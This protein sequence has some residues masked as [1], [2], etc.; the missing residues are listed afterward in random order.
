MKRLLVLLIFCL[1]LTSCNNL[2]ESIE[3]NANEIE[4][5]DK[6]QIENC[7]KYYY[8]N[9]EMIIVFSGGYENS[10]MIY[11]IN[12]FD[13]DMF[14]VKQYD[15]GAAV[16]RIYKVS[17]NQIEEIYGAQVYEDELFNDNGFNKDFKRNQIILKA[18]I[19]IGAKWNA[20][21]E[22]INEITG[23]DVDI[24]TPIGT[25]KV[26]EVTMVIDKDTKLKKYYAEGIGLVKSQMIVGVDVVSEDLIKQIYY[27]V[28]DFEDVESLYK[29]INCLN[30]TSYNNM[31]TLRVIEGTFKGQV[32][33]H[34]FTGCD[35]R[36]DGKSRMSGSATS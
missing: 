3:S 26:I 8:P 14:K 6:E 28:E 29:L 35:H 2:D 1:L 34:H 32:R 23:V 24:V 17:D 36:Q 4:N 31:F 30:K 20:N 11:L 13:K 25:L 21:D 22:Y 15:H 7:T 12:A 5:I 16:E 10:G 18:P 27:N 9:K 19:V 33:P